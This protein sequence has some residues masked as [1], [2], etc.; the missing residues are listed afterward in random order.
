[1]DELVHGRLGER[2]I[3]QLIVTTATEALQVR[4]RTIAMDPK[5][6]DQINENVLVELGAVLNGQARGSN[7]SLGIVAV[8]MDDWRTDHLGNVA[9]NISEDRGVCR[10]TDLE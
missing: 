8:D 1:M 6:P 10:Q 7:N 4:T 9:G 2:R 3:V 5:R